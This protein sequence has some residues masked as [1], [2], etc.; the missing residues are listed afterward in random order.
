MKIYI[1]GA[2]LIFVVLMF[3]QGCA[4][5]TDQGAGT[6]AQTSRSSKTIEVKGSDTMVNLGGAWAEA[7][8]AKGTGASV[9]VTGGG[10]GTGI[11]ALINGTTDIA[12]SS[13]NMSP[14]EFDSAKKS[15]MDPQEFIVAKD[16]VSVIVNKSNPISKLTVKQLADIFTGKITDWKSI[17]GTPGKMVVL[18]RDRSSG[19][20]VFVLEHVLRGGKSKGPEQ[21]GKEVLMQV[22]SQSI[23][24]EVAANKDAIGYVGMGYVDLAKHKHMFIA[25]DT[26]AK[27]I[28]PTPANVLNGTYPI[29][30]PLY[31]YTPDKPSADVKAFIDFVLSKEGQAIVTKEEFVS[32]K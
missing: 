31:F 26:G 13:R 21:F 11:A 15:G 9:S 27:Y 18:S 4:K 3:L 30:R 14:E 32:V 12:E 28:E 8:N 2:L 29:A 5:Q 6:T 17:G 10:S 23:A 16:G 22:S 20:H 1:Y 19:T 7:Y 24:D 25:K